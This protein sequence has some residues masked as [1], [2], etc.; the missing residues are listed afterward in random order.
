MM[1][2]VGHVYECV[3]GRRGLCVQCKRAGCIVAWTEIGGE[4]WRMSV[5]D[6]DGKPKSEGAP[7]IAHQVFPP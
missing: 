5:Y 3:D 4:D 6:R 1:L 2:V 7:Q